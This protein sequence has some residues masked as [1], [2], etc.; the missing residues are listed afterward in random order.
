M[1]VAQ[2]DASK[3]V[4]AKRRPH[5]AHV[6]TMKLSQAAITL[7]SFSSSAANIHFANAAS[8]PNRK[9]SQNKFPLFVKVIYF[10][11]GEDS[12]FYEVL[13]G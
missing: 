6:A 13:V 12:K 10:S 4:N 9:L 1:R 5:A 7:L 8:F 3:G 11:G 2:R